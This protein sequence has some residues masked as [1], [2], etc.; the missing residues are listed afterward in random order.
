MIPVLSKNV[1]CLNKNWVPVDTCTVSSAFIKL[2]SQRCKFLDSYNYTCHDIESWLLIEPKSSEDSLH[3]SKSRIKIPEI[4]ILNTK[5]IPK[6]KS[7]TFTKQ[8]IIRRDKN[9]C[10]FCRKK[11]SSGMMTIDHLTPKTKGGISCWENCVLSCTDC[12][13]K[14]ADRMLSEIRMNLIERIEMKLAY[15][16]DPKK[17]SSPFEPAWSP[18]FKVSAE[19]LIDSW[20][21]F[22]QPEFWSLSCSGIIQ[23]KK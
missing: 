17:W 12:N 20:R 13:S 5:I 7:I 15:P 21:Q 10:Q 23:V 9:T 4:I 19:N 16:K 1:L 3:T 8:N 11:L 2:F 14:K 18:L 6:R 22:F